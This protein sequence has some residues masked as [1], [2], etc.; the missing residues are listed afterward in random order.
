L[1]LS[2]SCLGRATLNVLKQTQST[3]VFQ[4]QPSFGLCSYTLAQAQNLEI[5][6]H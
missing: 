3:L 4:S 1:F 5:Y 6:H 2:D